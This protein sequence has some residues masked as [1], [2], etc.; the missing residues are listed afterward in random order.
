MKTGL[1]IED[2]KPFDYR[3]G[4]TYG[5]FPVKN[6]DW[7][8]M[9]YDNEMQVGLYFD[10]MSCVS[11]SFINAIQLYCLSVYGE[12]N[13]WS[14]RAIAKMSGTTR[15]GNSGG[16]VAETAR[17]QGILKEEDWGW[18]NRSKD[19]DEWAK[20]YSDIPEELVKKALEWLKEYEISYRWVERKDWKEALSVAPIQVYVRAWYKDKD[21]IFINKENKS[22]HAVVLLEESDYI[23]ILDSYDTPY[24]KKLAPD[25]VF[26]NWGL[27]ITLTKKNMFSKT[28][29]LLMTFLKDF[30]AR[31]DKRLIRNSKTNEVGYYY[32][33]SLITAKTQEQK[34][35]MLLAYLHRKDSN[36]SIS[37][38][39]WNKLPKREI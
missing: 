5:N 29:E 34:I 39:D 33:G 31:F 30:K 25:F 3:F 6:I 24:I 2:P 28:G 35:N 27:Q 11:Q 17:T 20:F 19:F 8:S 16:V 37:E 26:H 36:P 7:K 22:N 14:K 23:Y 10:T 18:N 21:G 4:G 32:D 12:Q 15:Q 38:E 1:I 13:Q 9:V